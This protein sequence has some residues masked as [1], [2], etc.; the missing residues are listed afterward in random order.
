MKRAILL[1]LILCLLAGCS[2]NKG[3]ATGTA[4]IEKLET[5]GDAIELE[6]ANFEQSAL[7]GEI[8]AAAL[9]DESLRHLR[10]DGIQGWKLGDVTIPE[11]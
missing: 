1:L 11:E 8:D 7:Y 4:A 10:I 6:G 2:G 3:P 9:N 5:I